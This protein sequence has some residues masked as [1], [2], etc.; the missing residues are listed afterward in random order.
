MIMY[1]ALYVNRQVA[2]CLLL[3][4]YYHYN[5]N[6]GTSSSLVYVSIMIIMVY[7][8]TCLWFF[9]VISRGFRLFLLSIQMKDANESELTNIK[10]VSC[11]RVDMVVKC[12]TV[13]QLHT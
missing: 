5:I 10:A 3:C 12:Y 2:A 11:Y 4:L 6:S 7:V 13:Y 8:I 9:D 1:I